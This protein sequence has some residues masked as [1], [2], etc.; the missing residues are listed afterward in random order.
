[1][2]RR[3]SSSGSCRSGVPAAVV[4]ARG[5]GALGPGRTHCVA[6]GHRVVGRQ[7][8]LLLPQ[9][10]RHLRQAADRIVLGVHQR[11]RRTRPRVGRSCC[12]RSRGPGRRRQPAGRSAP[13]RWL[14]SS[15]SPSP[16]WRRSPSPG[17]PRRLARTTWPRQPAPA[18]RRGHPVGRRPRCPRLGGSARQQTPRAGDH[19]VLH[20]RG[21]GVRHRRRL[22]RDQRLRT[23]RV[24][25]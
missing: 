12:R 20:P 11:L 25:R 22:R 2:W 15:G 9:R 3:W 17:T 16:R 10:L 13:S 21:L 14:R 6:V 5:R 4:E 19:A 1:M 7:R 8:R 23:A 18:P 24:V